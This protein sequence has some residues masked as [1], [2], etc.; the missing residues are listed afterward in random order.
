MYVFKQQYFAVI[1]CSKILT[2]KMYSR[3]M[4]CTQYEKGIVL[5]TNRS[6]TGRGK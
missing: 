1:Q 6:G 5:C 4:L 3:R 2:Q